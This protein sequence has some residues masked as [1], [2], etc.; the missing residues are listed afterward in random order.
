MTHDREFMPAPDD[1]VDS[2][3]PGLRIGVGGSAVPVDPGHDGYEDSAPGSAEEDP[4]DYSRVTKADAERDAYQSFESGMDDLGMSEQKSAHA[5]IGDRESIWCDLVA[6][7]EAT[8]EYARAY[9][10][11]VVA[12]NREHNP[13]EEVPKSKES[14]YCTG[15]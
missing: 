7:G 10:E 8:V 12:I 14:G 9:D 4:G 13:D 3:H 15:E 6:T 2:D 5:M 11:M 1:W